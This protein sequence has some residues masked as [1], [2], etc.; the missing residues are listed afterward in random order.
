MLR[1]SLSLAVWVLVGCD[2]PAQRAQQKLDR[3]EDLDPTNRPSSF[4][5]TP[6]EPGPPRDE[7]KEQLARAAQEAAKLSADLVKSGIPPREVAS[8]ADIRGYRLF[9]KRYFGMARRWFMTAARTDPSFEP[10]HYNAARAAALLG[11]TA[12]ARR[13]LERLRELGTPMSRRKLQLARR[14]P[15]FAPLWK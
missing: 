6:R 13:H 3:G 7:T 11:D 10:A 14:H 5:P 2:C 1:I 9:R 12:A 4:E 8:M 15:D